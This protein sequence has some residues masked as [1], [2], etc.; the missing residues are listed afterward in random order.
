MTE[1]PYINERP[2][3]T[4]YVTDEQGEYLILRNI[5]RDLPH[6]PFQGD[7]LSSLPHPLE[8]HVVH[9]LG[10]ALIYLH[11]G[12][13]VA[14]S[15]TPSEKTNS[16]ARV[17]SWNPAFEGLPKHCR[18]LVVTGGDRAVLRWLKEREYWS[19]LEE[20]Y[21]EIKAQLDRRQLQGDLDVTFGGAP[22]PRDY[23]TLCAEVDM[24]LDLYWDRLLDWFP[25]LAES[26]W[27]DWAETADRLGFSHAL[28]E[29]AR[30]TS[31]AIRRST[32]QGD[33]VYEYDFDCGSVSVTTQGGEW[34]K[35]H[36][37]AN[38]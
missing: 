10:H 36:F 34:Q 30:V 21:W 1:G 29:D 25:R 27:W 16:S 22:G 8:G 23:D 14:I 6:G 31:E 3:D 20:C 12:V 13:P 4:Q 15:M 35:F 32:G 26:K 5:P 28:T 18:R 38:K 19:P 33:G 24:I 7:G 37:Q 2:W 11:F 17:L 9:E